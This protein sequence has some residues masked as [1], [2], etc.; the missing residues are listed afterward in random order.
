MLAE[1]GAL[2]LVVGKLAVEHIGPRTADGTAERLRIWVDDQRVG[3]LGFQRSRRRDKQRGRTD[4]RCDVPAIT[5]GTHPI[6][7]TRLA[8]PR[9]PGSAEP[10]A[11]RSGS[12]E[13]GTIGVVGP[14]P[15]SSPASVVIPAAS[16]TASLRAVPAK[17]RCPAPRS[18]ATVDV[19][20]H[21]GRVG[22]RLPA[23]RPGKAQMSGTPIRGHRGCD[24]LSPV[25][26]R[27][28]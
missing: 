28:A 10:G 15:K 21:P 11:S 5:F 6:D 14:S 27:A 9:S 1:I 23:G 22:N 2:Q 4:T 17:P 8:Q 25:T 24:C 3:L 26:M 20:G 19:T 12:H 13:P 7:P 16:A 18:E